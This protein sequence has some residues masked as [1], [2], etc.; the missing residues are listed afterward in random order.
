MLKLCNFL[1]YDFLSCLST[2]ACVKTLIEFPPFGH[3][4]EWVYETEEWNDVG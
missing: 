4:E 2:I 3:P 1:S